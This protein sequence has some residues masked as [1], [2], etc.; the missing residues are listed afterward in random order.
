MPLQTSACNRTKS[1]AADSPQQN[2]L[3]ASSDMQHRLPES[4]TKVYK[5]EEW[6]K[7]KKVL[8]LNKWE[9]KHKEVADKSL[10]NNLS[11]FNYIINQ[12]ALWSLS[13][14]FSLHVTERPGG[15]LVSKQIFWKRQ[16][17]AVWNMHIIYSSKYSTTAK[18]PHTL[19]SHIVA[20]AL[21]CK[22]M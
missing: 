12:C 3:S 4:L 10:R 15:N 7:E 17:H 20:Y 8:K 21:L 16:C 6:K 18:V 1:A 11:S 22:H 2:L 13:K 5:K 9:K 19:L 14:R